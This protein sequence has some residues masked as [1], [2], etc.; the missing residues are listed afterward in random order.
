MACLPPLYLFSCF[1]RSMLSLVRVNA[2]V[3]LPIAKWDAR[4]IWYF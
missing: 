1:G 3:D 2:G 4:A